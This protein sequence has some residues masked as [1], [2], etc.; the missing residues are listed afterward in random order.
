[1]N[2]QLSQILFQLINFGVVF[3]ALLYL[4]YKPVLK[5]LHER[6]KKIQD[7]QQ[8]AEQLIQQKAETEKMTQK[9]LNQAKKEATDLLAETKKLA[10]KK[11]DEL[12]S[13]AK[14]E[15]Q[16]F[17]S[18]EKS[19]W[20]QEKQQMIKHLEK[21]MSEAVF[22]ISEKVLGESIDTKTHGKLIDQGIAEV[23]KSL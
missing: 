10:D 18:D 21:E 12:M 2:I 1:M 22:S 7:S 5:T 20:L 8:A 17:L 19:K 6:S 23:L 16:Q 13:K 9:S 14:T 11:K 4:V 3:G 15:V